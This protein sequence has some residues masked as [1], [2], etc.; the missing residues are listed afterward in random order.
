MTVSIVT[1]HTPEQELRQGLRSL[2][3]PV[4]DKIYIVDNGREERLRALAAEYERVEYIP[5]KNEGYGA[6]HNIA[7]RR[8]MPGTLPAIKQEEHDNTYILENLENSDNLG[9]L[10]HPENSDSHGEEPAT[11]SEY[12]LVLNSDVYF[13][14]EL[15]DQMVEVMKK[16]PEIGLLH[17]RLVYPDGKLQPTARLLPTPWDVFGRRFLPKRLFA[18]R[19]AKYTLEGLDLTRAHNVPYVQGS[20]MLMRLSALREV[21]LF[22]ERFFMYPEDIDLSRRL[23]SS[24]KTLYWPMLSAVHAHRAASYHNLRMLRIH[25]VNMIRYFNKWGWFY[26]PERRLFNRAHLRQIPR[27]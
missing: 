25:I 5:A 16:D 7:I 4:V 11:G 14:P 23:H 8:A 2:T 22:D 10:D 9:N 6:G 21:G 26:D 18:K 27:K 20:F 1:Y 19:N 17:P 15:L 13:E 24:Y 3:S 12:H